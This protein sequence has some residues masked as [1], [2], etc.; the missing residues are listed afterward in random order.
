[1]THV[2][3]PMVDLFKLSLKPRVLVSFPLKIVPPKWL[4]RRTESSNQ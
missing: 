3:L 4:V 2:S 1:M